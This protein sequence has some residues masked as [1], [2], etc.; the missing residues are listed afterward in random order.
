MDA[1]TWQTRHDDLLWS[2][3]DRAYVGSLMH[4]LTEPGQ[5]AAWLAPPARGING[6]PVEFDYVRFV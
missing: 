2:E 6:M 4:P 1:A 3:A 5:M